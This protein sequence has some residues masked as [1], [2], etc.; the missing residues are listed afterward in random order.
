MSG[1]RQEKDKAHN[2]S[3]GLDLSH[4]VNATKVSRASLIR[5]SS[6]VLGGLISEAWWGSRD[7][8][9]ETTLFIIDACPGM[10]D[11]IDGPPVCSL[12]ETRYTKADG[13]T[14]LW[15]SREL[16]H[17]WHLSAVTKVVR[18]A[19]WDI[20]HFYHPVSGVGMSIRENKMDWH[21]LEGR[22]G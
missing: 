14:H 2:G 9:L 15:P 13:W 5:T 12:I 6:G 11:I 16:L 22:A 3:V 21:E 7:Q 17:P 20:I 10:T 4:P 18:R 19:L 8:K 1:D